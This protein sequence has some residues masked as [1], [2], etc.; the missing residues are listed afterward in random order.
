MIEVSRRVDASP[1]DVFAVVGDGW[2]FASWVVGAA[3][4]RAVDPAWPAV[5]SRLHHSIGPW[6]VSIQDVTTVTAVRPG[7]HIELAA[8]MW[9]IGAA[10]V[11][12]LLTPVPG[13]GTEMTLAEE[14]TQGPVRLAPTAVQGLLLR[15]RNEESLRRLAD[16]A[17]GRRRPT[18]VPT[19]HDDSTRP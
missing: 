13:G 6:P 15:P 5:G 9:P 4:I 17:I 2:T 11:R 8:R 1:D 19:E 18:E 3:H 12:L 10:R 16:L 7:S 14:A